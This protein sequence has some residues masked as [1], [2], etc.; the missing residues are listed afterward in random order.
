MQE[1]DCVEQSIHEFELQ[2][3]YR[4]GA[5]IKA[6]N[7]FSKDWW[8][9]RRFFWERTLAEV[10]HCVVFV[11]D[12]SSDP[13][14]DQESLEFFKEVFKDCTNH[15]QY[16]N[17]TH[18]FSVHHEYTQIHT[19]SLS[20]SL[21]HIHTLKH[22]Y[23]HTRSHTGYEPIIVVTCLDLIH[24]EAL[25]HG[26]NF[27]VEVQHKKDKVLEAF[28]KLNLTRNSVYFVTNFHEGWRGVRVWGEGDR[29]FEKASKSMVDLAR[30]MLAVADRFITRKY[31]NESKCTVL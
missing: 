14:L 12:G 10:P 1:Y 7:F 21:H 26:F 30:D 23:T 16:L 19:A 28:E 6:S 2:G 15:G 25:R 13:F 22:T 8:L 20:L 9:S 17:F 27:E 29:G 4:D 24:Q 31:T 3:M 18:K 5:E 11:F